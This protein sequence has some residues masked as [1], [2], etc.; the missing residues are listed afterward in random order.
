[1]ATE[2]TIAW[3]LRYNAMVAAS[4]GA[5]VIAE[6]DDATAV[7]VIVGFGYWRSS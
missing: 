4:A 7:I 5:V 1:M 6:I 2:S 3:L